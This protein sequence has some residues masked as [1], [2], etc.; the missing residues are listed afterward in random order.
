MAEQNPA[1][2]QQNSGR[3][4]NEANLRQSPLKRDFSSPSH[5]CLFQSRNGLLAIDGRA[6]PGLDT[7]P[8]QGLA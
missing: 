6:H 3:G 4:R 8:D 7:E 5:Q 1:R 2:R